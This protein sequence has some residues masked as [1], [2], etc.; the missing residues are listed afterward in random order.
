LNIEKA[1][2]FIQEYYELCKKHQMF[3]ITCQ[4]PDCQCTFPYPYDEEWEVEEVYEDL[5]DWFV[6]RRKDF[7]LEN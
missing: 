1:Y 2:Q 6:Q 5:I 7:E 4:D 3:I